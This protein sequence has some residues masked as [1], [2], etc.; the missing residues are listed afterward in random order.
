[1][2]QFP[3]LVRRDVGS[4]NKIVGDARSAHPIRHQFF[5]HRPAGRSRVAVNNEIY[6]RMHG[7]AVCGKGTKDPNLD[8]ASVGIGHYS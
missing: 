6:I 8:P 4:K 3:H 1:M 5:D 2:K 7:K